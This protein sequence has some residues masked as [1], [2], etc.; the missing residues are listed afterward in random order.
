MAEKKYNA[1][2]IEILEGLEAVRI[3]PGM[4]IGSTGKTG[5][6][7][8]LWEIVDNAV[9]E[10][11]NGFAD[12]IDV[13]LNGDGSVSVED[14]GRGIPTD[15]HPKMGI[16]GV[17]VVFTQLHAGGKFDNHNYSY[18]GGLHGVGASVTNALSE[19]LKVE[20]YRGTV[21]RME[22]HSYFD[23]AEKK[24]HSG[25]P[26]APLTNTKK[27]TTKK[28][29]LV[30]FK[31]DAAVFET[32]RF[33]Y[34]V[35]SKHLKEVAFLNKGLRLRLTDYRG[36]EVKTVEYCYEGGI[37]D[38]VLD[39]NRNSGKTV[40]FNTPVYCSGEVDGIRIE[41]AIQYTD[42]FTDTIIS[43][44]NNIPT[45]EGGMHEV[46]FK[47]GLTKVL[48]DYARKEKYLKEKDDNFLGDDFREGITAVLSIKMKNVQ[49]EGQT[50]TKLGNPEARPAVDSFTVSALQNFANEKGANAVFDAIMKKAQGAAKARLAAK[51]AKEIARSK[52]AI[53]SFN[54]LGKL[55]ACRSKK[56]E[57]NELF[58]VEGDSAGGSAKQGRDSLYQ[59]ILPLRG[60][61]LNVEKKRIDQV[62]ANEEI[63]TLISALGTDIGEDFQIKDLNF[64]KVIILSDADQDGA[65]I[66]AILLTFFF[67][68]MKPLI[69]EGHVYIGMPPLYKVYK[70]DR[71]EYAYDDSELQAKIDLVGRGYQIQRYKGLGEMNPE[72]LWETTMNPESRS[73]MRV[74]IE[75]GSEAERLIS[76]LLGDSID[77]RKQ[78][79]TEHANFNKEDAFIKLKK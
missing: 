42:A 62:I 20:V 63:R 6:H 34:E 11:A 12:F 45:P 60:K 25:V 23:E 74:T 19:W 40:L 33:D 27:K 21:Y 61:P 18:S 68:Y 3:R 47:S 31:P 44:V 9:D 56:A 39:I 64:D 75:D 32:T 16:S 36:N 43:Y 1:G 15:I 10:A 59:A 70:K 30:T 77:L 58:I 57:R 52:N 38:F 35:I 65:H 5:L 53:D 79:I 26:V 46:G 22:F 28:G 66:R 76:T 48:N 71:V 54:T 14:N 67:R 41:F 51:H 73:L 4:Y 37:R 55:A 49:F 13:K 17:E 2:D 29:T 69:T 24:Y 72:Q 8:I 78:Y 7:H 50:K